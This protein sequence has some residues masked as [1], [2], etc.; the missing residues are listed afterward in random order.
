M[1]EINKN[2]KLK[3]ELDQ[4][5]DLIIKKF[6][7]PASIDIAEN[8]SSQDL[9]VATKDS[10]DPVIIKAINKQLKAYEDLGNAYRKSG[11]ALE[12]ISFEINEIKQ[13][14][15]YPAKGSKYHN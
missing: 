11:K 1:S 12:A 14:K 15:Y 6:N 7:I 4:D 8:N 2:I 3:K 10:K 5:I 9:I 13:V